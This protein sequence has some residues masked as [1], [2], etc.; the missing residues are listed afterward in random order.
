LS[1]GVKGIGF[2]AFK[3]IIYS[4]AIRAVYAARKTGAVCIEL[5]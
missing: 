5:T 4:G 1:R 2:N 3:T